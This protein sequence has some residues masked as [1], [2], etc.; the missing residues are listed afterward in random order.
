MWSARTVSIVMNNTFGCGGCA[1]AWLPPTTDATRPQRTMN[2]D[3]RMA[4]SSVLYARQPIPQLGR[5]GQRRQAGAQR[6]DRERRLI[7]P[8]VHVGQRE[9]DR[10]ERR[11]DERGAAPGADRVAVVAGTVKGPAEEK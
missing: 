8:H 2:L 3:Q 10:H 6:L 5:V 1:A 11:I 7:Q 4:R 9:M